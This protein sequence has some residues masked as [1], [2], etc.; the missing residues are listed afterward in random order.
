[1][2]NTPS[3]EASRRQPHKLSKPRVGNLASNSPSHSNLKS[4]SVPSASALL[5]T[6]HLVDSASPRTA[7]RFLDGTDREDGAGNECI[8]SPVE[9]ALPQISRRSSKVEPSRRMSGLFR[10]KSSIT[11]KEARRTSA[12]ILGDQLVRAKSAVQSKTQPP[13]PPLQRFVIQD[14]CAVPR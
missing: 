6:P 7:E 10:S 14:I 5:S 9:N 11:D 4:P 13:S 12:M 8:P 3:S 2:G 1:M